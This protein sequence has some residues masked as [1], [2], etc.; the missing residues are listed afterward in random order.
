MS[1]RYQA[2][3]QPQ[4]ADEFSAGSEATIRALEICSETALLPHRF[5]HSRAGYERLM[6][7]T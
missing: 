3:S 6:R 7:V 5:A 2:A 4:V 1:C